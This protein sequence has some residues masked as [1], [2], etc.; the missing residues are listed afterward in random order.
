MTLLPSPRA[1][2]TS[3]AIFQEMG[4][5]VRPLPRKKLFAVAATIAGRGLDGDFRLTVTRLA[6]SRAKPKESNPGPRFA[7]VPGTEIV[8]EEGGDFF[9]LGIV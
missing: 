3:P 5:G 2:G 4:R 9:C 7:D 6:R 8:T 1:W